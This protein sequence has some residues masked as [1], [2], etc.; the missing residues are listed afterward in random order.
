[1]SG[2]GGKERKEVTS[3]VQEIQ[4]RTVKAACWQ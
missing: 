3:N 2:S 1:M 4:S